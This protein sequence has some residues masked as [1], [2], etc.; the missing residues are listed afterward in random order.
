LIVTTAGELCSRAGRLNLT[1]FGGL[2]PE[3]SLR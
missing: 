3:S 2:E 1:E